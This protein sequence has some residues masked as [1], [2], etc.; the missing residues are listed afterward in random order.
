KSN[1]AWIAVTS[2]ASGSGTGSVG[3]SFAANAGAPRAGTIT[4]AG[5][6][7]TINQGSSCTYTVTPA[8]TVAAGG[9]AA[10][11]T[12]T[13]G[14]SC[15]WTASSVL[16]WANISSPT[17]SVTG[18]GAVTLQVQANSITTARSGSITV[19]SQSVPLNQF[20]TGFFDFNGDAVADLLFYDAN[21]G[22]WSA[23]ITGGGAFGGGGSWPAGL[24]VQPVDLDGNGRT[25]VFGY[26]ATSGAWAKALDDGS[27]FST[28]TGTWWPG[29][30]VSLLDLDGRGQYS[31]FLDNG[32][33]LMT[34]LATGI[35]GESQARP[36]LSSDRLR[37]YFSSTRAS[38]S[39]Q[40]I[41]VASRGSAAAAFEP[42]VAIAAL[43]LPNSHAAAPSLTSNE[44][45]IVFE[46]DRAGGMGGADVW[47]AERATPTS[48]FSA[49]QPL[50][51]INSSSRD[52][53]P[54][55][56]V[57]G[58]SLYFESDRAGGVGGADIWFAT[59]DALSSPF[60]G[61]AN[62]TAINS[63]GVES[64][65]A[66]SGDTQTLYFWSDRPNGSATANIWRAR[67]R[68]DAASAAQSSFSATGA[69]T[70]ITVT[71]KSGCSWVA[72]TTS[73]W[74]T[75][76]SP[77]SGAGPGSV[78]M[79]VA[80]NTGLP[81]TG[82]V[83]IGGQTILVSPDALAATAPAPP[84]P[85]PPPPP[86]TPAPSPSPSPAPS[87]SPDPVSAPASP[88]S[89]DAPS[90]APPSDPGAPLNLRSFVSGSTVTL[91]WDSPAS[92]SP[93]QYLIEAGSRPGAS[94]LA[95]VVTGDVTFTA[96]GVGSGVYMVRVRS[97][98]PDHVSGASNE[99]AVVVGGGCSSAPIAP[100]GLTYSV[101]G[102]TVVLTWNAASGAVTSYV[103]VA[104]YSSHAS[105]AA[106]ADTGNGYP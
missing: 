1:D 61:A 10:T 20:G 84:P 53:S 33:G 49:P 46:S 43:N 87:P 99:I 28:V 95:Q 9:G 60:G 86:P 19:A 16:S 48:P 70:T 24:T 96:Y 104:G 89:G 42:P 31:V 38:G 22:V 64:H 76:L 21:S 26:N 88:P 5:Q 8:P 67:V 35:P 41:F 36:W 17:G 25:D 54:E 40:N 73:S 52:G 63:G 101:S 94:D 68:C 6:T 77:A 27:G 106:H 14:A 51:G 83:N 44:R 13:T 92:G 90:P 78:M 85:P 66:V 45:T 55:L 15:S 93:V 18:N 29:W 58:L 39:F 4:I 32:V 3:Y 98:Y 50:S 82:A 102:S 47:M 34:P 69:A 80:A 23:S 59:R 71:D 12:V 30:Q 37:I 56:S 65:P 57:D 91:G 7:F 2:G 97:L 75:F 100:T 74:I 105:D 62:F 79:I 11:V 103:L 81:R 72:Q